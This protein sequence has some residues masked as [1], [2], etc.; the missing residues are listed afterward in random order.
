MTILITF[1]TLLTVFLVAIGFLVMLWPGTAVTELNCTLIFQS[2]YGD[3]LSHMNVNI[4]DSPI[5][6]THYKNFIY[7]SIKEIQTDDKGRVTFQTSLQH[8]VTYLEAI[9]LK[10]NRIKKPPFTVAFHSSSFKKNNFIYTLLVAP[11]KTTLQT[12]AMNA[13]L[14]YVL[15]PEVQPEFGVES[16]VQRT[17]KGWNLTITLKEL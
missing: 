17:P 3:P 4:Y 12:F 5:I 9:I 15:H 10:I 8:G 7:N 1:L 2:P 14:N 6:T 11:K 13:H 16:V